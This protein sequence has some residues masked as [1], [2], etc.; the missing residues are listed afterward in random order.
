MR[1]CPLLPDSHLPL[2]IPLSLP[3]PWLPAL[4][5]PNPL[6]HHCLPSLLWSSFPGTGSCCS[7]PIS[8]VY[9]GWVGFSLCPELPWDIPAEEQGWVEFDKLNLGLSLNPF[10]AE[11]L[12]SGYPCRGVWGC[13][14]QPDVPQGTQKPHKDITKTPQRHHKNPT[15]TPQRPH[16]VK[17]TSGAPEGRG[18]GT[19]RQV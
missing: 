16:R 1:A 13:Y 2:S 17:S 18:R 5:L 10:D 8:P 11:S 19:A 4:C 3:S 9:P 14:I 7:P 12:S 15:E 6:L